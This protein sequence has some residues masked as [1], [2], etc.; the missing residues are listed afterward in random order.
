MVVGLEELLG[1]LLRDSVTRQQAG[2]VEPIRDVYQD[3][4]QLANLV[5]VRRFQA[6]AFGAVFAT[7]RR[8]C[9]GTPLSR[10][11][12]GTLVFIAGFD[13]RVRYFARTLP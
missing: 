10:V 8:S 7:S 5:G 4:Q 9:E 13:Y 2:H 3:V 1:F 6:V 12:Y 11:G